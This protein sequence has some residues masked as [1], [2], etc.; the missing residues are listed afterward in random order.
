ML[1]QVEFRPHINGIL[2]VVVNPHPKWKRPIQVGYCRA[3]GS[4][5]PTWGR[6]N[7]MNNHGLSP[8]N[9]RLVQAFLRRQF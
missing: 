5:I 7:L 1:F 3:D 6:A 9:L 2:K 4:D 8:G